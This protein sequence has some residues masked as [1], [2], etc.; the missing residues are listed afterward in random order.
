[1]SVVA[2][3]VELPEVDPMAVSGVAAEAHSCPAEAMVPAHMRPRLAHILVEA[4]AAQNCPHFAFVRKCHP[5]PWAEAVM[6]RNP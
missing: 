6:G 4:V 5:H 3:V 1:M 2:R